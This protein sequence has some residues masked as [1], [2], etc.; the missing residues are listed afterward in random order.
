VKKGNYLGTEIDHRWW[1]R[2]R[3]PGFFA[4]GS[5]EF[6]MDETGVWFRRLLTGS[7]LTISWREMTTAKLGTWH[8]GQ[9]VLGRPVL[10][11]EYE[12][13]GQHLS[14]GFCFSR[15]KDRGDWHWMEQLVA[16][17]NLKIGG[18]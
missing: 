16:D 1:K 9:W 17:L 8:A 18:S 15:G 3:A 13:E 2:Y 10:K 6:W 7:P 5:G 14:A 12:R 11:I 4:R